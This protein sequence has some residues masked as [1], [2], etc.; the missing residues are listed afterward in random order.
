[1]AKPSSYSNT[2]YTEQSILNDSFDTN[3]RTLVVQQVAKD[4]DGN[5]HYVPTEVL[6]D[7][8]SVDLTDP[9]DI[10][11]YYKFDGN[12]V[13]TEEITTNGSLIEIIKT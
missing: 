1:M 3:S 9:N 2:T 12:V 11:I 10:F 7:T 5:L 8:T 13:A 4:P 6:Y